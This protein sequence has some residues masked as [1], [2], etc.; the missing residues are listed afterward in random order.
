MKA[1]TMGFEA[2]P[3][4]IMLQPPTNP[5]I[6]ER[7][8]PDALFGGGAAGQQV[9]PCGQAAAAADGRGPRR[10]LPVRSLSLCRG[11]HA[12]E[13]TTGVRVWPFCIFPVQQD[14]RPLTLPPN[15]GHRD[16]LDPALRT[17]EGLT[18]FLLGSQAEDCGPFCFSRVQNVGKSSSW[19]RDLLLFWREGEG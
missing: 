6:Q 9:V 3:P 17:S 14:P 15:R 10:A 8:P 18:A 5:H 19:G 4:P 11:F 12:M 7:R 1:G 2:H 13:G 16:G